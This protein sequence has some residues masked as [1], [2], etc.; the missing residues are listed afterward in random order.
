MRLFLIR[1]GRPDIAPG[2]CYGSSDVAVAPDEHARVAAAVLAAL[3]QATVHAS[4]LRRCREL[5]A[6]IATAL[7]SGD[8]VHDPRLAEMDFGRW[9]M[10]AWDD[11]PRA[12]IG[13]WA[14]DP[15]GYRPGG[16]ENVLD[17]ARRVQAFYHALQARRVDS[18]I[19]VCHAGTMRLLA[20]CR[21]KPTLREIALHAAQT[22][23]NIA[24]GELLILDC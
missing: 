15:A 18:A 20:A 11:I 9:E 2:I 5:A 10:R 22:R 19:V 24:Y 1:H 3:P 16:A 8:V 6:L 12:E 4:P 7:G 14:N 23:N 13:A 17:A 21:H